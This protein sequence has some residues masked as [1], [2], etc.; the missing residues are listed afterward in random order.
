MKIFIAGAGE[1]GS[2]LATL[3]S[4]EDH[5]III[6]DS[7]PS[8]LE[9]AYDNSLE[10]LPILGNPTS[11]ADLKNAG[12]AGSDLFISVTPEESTNITA[13]ILAHNLG[14]QKTMARINNQ[15]YLQEPNAAFFRDLGVNYMVYPELLAAQE[16][17]DG[18]RLPWTRQYWSLSEGR[19]QLLAVKMMPGAPLIG[20]YLSELSKTEKYFHIVAIKRKQETIIPRG[21]SK[22]EVGDIIF[23]TCEKQN[24]DKVR[25]FCG[26]ENSEVKKI[27]MMGGSRIAIKTVE[28]LPSNIKAK[29]IDTDYEKCKQMA[30][31]VP[32]NTMII[33]GDG[34]DPQLLQAEGIE[35][36]QCFAALTGNS[37]T[38]LLATL[39][40]KRMGVYRSIARIE[41]IDYLSIAEQMEI[42]ILI[43]KK[44]IAAGSIYRHL[45]NVDVNNVKCL[46]IANA[47]VVELVAKK[48]S[49][50]T[51]KQIKDLKLPNE[52]S[53][54]ALIRDGKMQL[55]EGST[56]V[57]PNDVVL[58][59]CLGHSLVKLR[60]FFS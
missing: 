2:H 17:V 24:L 44:L 16:I 23:V 21:N 10:V 33:H 49:K 58:A 11:L 25:V 32:S 59:F 47:D 13:S 26:K 30:K 34:R 31:R 42:G 27:I 29:I 8:R 51:T 53:L 60:H 50:I 54:G 3:L 36:V 28:L 20:I 52:I 48:G 14:A 6:M 7:D 55:V 4:R 43:N 41:N 35:D 45:L 56:I 22:I 15:E 46:A 57:Q 9:F 38:N 1:V 12:I 40:A 19:V 18:V 37:E 39:A 5:D